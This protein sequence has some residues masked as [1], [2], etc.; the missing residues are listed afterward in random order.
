MD[1]KSWKACIRGIHDE[2]YVDLV[3]TAECGAFDGGCLVVA[4]AL[5]AVIGGDIVVI[6]RR[7]DTADHA[8]VLKDGMLWDYDGPRK[9]QSFI[10]RFTRTELRGLP[11]K[12]V[13]FRPIRSLDL[14][15]AYV[16]EALEERLAEIFARALPDEIRLGAT[17]PQAC[18]R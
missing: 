13:G 18:A 17:S 5:Q 3:G 6:V 12:A 4:K 7:D 2:F 15:Y 9:P 16:D 8:A 1:I 11:W 14:P 10:D